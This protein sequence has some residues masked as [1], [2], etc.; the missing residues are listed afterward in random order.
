[1]DCFTAEKGGRIMNNK[2]SDLTKVLQRIQSLHGDIPAELFYCEEGQFGGDDVGEISVI[3]NGNGNGSIVAI[4]SKELLPLV[5]I[6][7]NPKIGMKILKTYVDAPS[8][9][10]YTNEIRSES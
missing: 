5:E 6:S 8:L 7:K 9:S 10:L 3:D 2:I 1:M 4:C